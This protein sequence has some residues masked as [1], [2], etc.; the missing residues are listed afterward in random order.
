MMAIERQEKIMQILATNKS[1]SVKE[2][3]ELLQASE[4]TIRRDLTLLEKDNKLERTHGGAYINEN[5]QL[6][7][8]E[9]F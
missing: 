9:T 4:A 2:L 7:Y 5:I 1:A 8:E 6:N 3:C